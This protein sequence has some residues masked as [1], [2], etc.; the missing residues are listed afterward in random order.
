[1]KE[2]SFI[3]SSLFLAGLAGAKSGDK[4]KSFSSS[5]SSQGAGPLHY[6]S[7]LEY[8]R[9]G[10]SGYRK[11]STSPACGG[12]GKQ[13]LGGRGVSPSPGARKDFRK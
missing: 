2:D 8:P 9:P 5:G 4:G 7:P 1:M 12:D 10:S 3:S 6:Y 13:G 11:Q